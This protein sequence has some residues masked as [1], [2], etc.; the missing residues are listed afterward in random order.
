MVVTVSTL[1]ILNLR[2]GGKF[3]AHGNLAIVHIDCCLQGRLLLLLARIG[4]IAP[5]CPR[6]YVTL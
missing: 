4:G 1:I 6:V 5:E 2:G 3:A